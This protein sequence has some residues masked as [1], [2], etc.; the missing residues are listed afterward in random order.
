[1]KRITLTL[2]ITLISLA[3]NAFPCGKYGFNFVGKVFPGEIKI[4]WS[5]AQGLNSCGLEKEEI[6]KHRFIIRVAGLFEDEVIL[7]DTTALNY[8][9][10]NTHLINNKPVVF[11]IEELGSNEHSLE[12]LINPEQE[13]LPKL[14]SKI[15]TLNFYLMNGYFLNALSLL[16]NINLAELVNEISKEYDVLFPAYYPYE[17]TYFN[18]YLD[19]STMKMN[20][21]PVVGGL[22]ESVKSL[23]KL[24]KK[25]PKR[26]KGFKV[27]AK[28][29]QDGTLMD[30]EVIPSSDKQ[31]FDKVVNLLTF[32]K[33]SNE[34]NQVVII[35]GRTKS[36]K[37]FTII[38]ERALMDQNFQFFK[39]RFPYRGAVN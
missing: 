1:M 3:L 30:Y 21:V 33:M 18:S 6:L 15:D 28:I 12:L 39:T 9:S 36:K 38:N 7:V 13:Q 24:T 14:E 5:I 8:F 25:E 34:F 19:A 22:A 10:M 2:L 32:S 27:Y 16:D 20:K 29:K 11:R 4:S 17:Q 23:N 37:E 35:I 26:D 31:N